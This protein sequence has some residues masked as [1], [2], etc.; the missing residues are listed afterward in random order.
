M[1]CMHVLRNMISTLFQLWYGVW[2]LAGLTQPIIT[3]FGA[4]RLPETDRYFRQALILAGRFAQN[5]VSVLTGG[6]QGIMEAASCGAEKIGGKGRVIGIGVSELKEKP[7]PCVQEYIELRYF[8]ARKW[9]LVRYSQAYVF[10]PGGYGTLDELTE[11][12]TL[13]QVK[14]V[15]RRPIVLFGSEYWEPFMNWLQHEAV[16][17]G[18]IEKENLLLFTVTDDLDQAFL[19]VCDKCR[20]AV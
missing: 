15:P 8:F 17:H 12:L 9:L 7:N 5:N 14:Q 10:F 16:K 2:R 19:L 3:I 6:G 1:L 18:T 20:S 4:S 13:M 11:I